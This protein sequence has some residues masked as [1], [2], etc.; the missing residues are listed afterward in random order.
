MDYRLRIT[1]VMHQQLSGYRVKEKIYLGV[2]ERKSL[3]IAVLYNGYRVSCPGVKRPG[4]DANRP[5][6]SSAE[7]KET[8][9]LYLYSPSG[10]SRPVIGRTLPFFSPFSTLG[11]FLYSEGGS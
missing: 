9:E 11:V 4:R 6:P 5:P 10:R 8:V 7:F 2:R 3:N 1:S